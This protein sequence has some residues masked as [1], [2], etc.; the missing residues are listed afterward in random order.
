MAETP[1]EH[2][3]TPTEGF[4][5]IDGEGFYV[6]PDVD[7]MAPFLMSIV[8]DSD[9]WMFVSSRGGAD[10]RPAKRCVGAV[11]LRDR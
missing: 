9:H 6:I 10:R 11:S 4:I 7:R 5:D 3:G 8:S 1:I 2:S